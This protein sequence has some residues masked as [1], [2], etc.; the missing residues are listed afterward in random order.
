MKQKIILLSLMG[1]GLCAGAQQKKK[2]V[3]PK[4]GY[5]VDGYIEGLKTP[6]VY[7]SVGGKRDSVPV[8]DGKFTYKGSVDEP[9]GAYLTDQASFGE[10]FYVENAPVTIRGKMTELS[11]F[12]VTGG[13]TQE[14]ENALKAS[15][16]SVNTKISQLYKD[17]DVAEKAKD[18]VAVERIEKELKQLDAEEHQLTKTFLSS[19]PKSYVSLNK[20]KGMGYSVDYSEI[21]QLFQSLDAGLRNSAAGKKVEATIAVLKR[22]GN[23]QKMIDFTQNDLSGKPVNFSSFKGKYVLVDFWASWCGPCRAENP[24]VLKAYQKFSPKGF[25]VLGVSLDDSAE[26]WKK[27]VEDDKMPWTQ[28]SDLKGWKNE[29]STYYGIQGIP[30]NYLVDPNGVIVARNL[31]GVALERKLQ[32]VLK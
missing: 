23:G 30:S 28:V 12:K 15:T 32:E 1:L 31:R 14:E 26:K 16:K 19:H 25:T 6:Y 20:I 9:S 5:T 7:L 24:N 22:G 3:T 21:E 10:M 13:K 17:Y 8:K 2:V 27:A 11:D 18:S 29:V 4:A